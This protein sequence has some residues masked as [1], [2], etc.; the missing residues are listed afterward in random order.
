M[1]QALCISW[2]QE[3]LPSKDFTCELC[4]PCRAQHNPKMNQC[5]GRVLKPKCKIS[6][7]MISK[8]QKEKNESETIYPEGY[9][10]SFNELHMFTPHSVIQRWLELPTVLQNLYHSL[11]L[12]AVLIT[13][14]F[15]FQ[16]LKLSNIYLITADLISVL[17]RIRFIVD[18][19]TFSDLYGDF[20]VH[21]Y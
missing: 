2:N 21:S 15:L 4:D 3:Q 13:E 6:Q 19:F 20:A 18:C 12:Q 7:W 8:S 16:S 9:P 11:L 1:P 14:M 10:K 5:Q 17:I